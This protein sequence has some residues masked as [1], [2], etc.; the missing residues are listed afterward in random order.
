[1]LFVVPFGH[2]FFLRNWVEYKKN[3]KDRTTSV[4]MAFPKKPK[5][6]SDLIN[7]GLRTLNEVKI[8]YWLD[9]TKNL[10]EGGNGC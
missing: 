2:F 6:N 4:H 3:T 8:I 1:M 5:K 9:G 10:V 7:A